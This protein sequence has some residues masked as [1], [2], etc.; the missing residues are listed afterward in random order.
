MLD[1]KN[2][3]IIANNIYI[4]FHNKDVG[5]LTDTDRDRLMGSLK[6]IEADVNLLI[7]RLKLDKI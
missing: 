3:Y 7:E 4:E 1:F 5:K 2:I 6:H